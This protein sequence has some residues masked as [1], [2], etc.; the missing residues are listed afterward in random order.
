MIKED[1]TGKIFN[2]LTVL[3]FSHY[4]IKYY[5]KSL[6]PTYVYYWLCKCKCGK[7]IIAEHYHLKYGHTKSCGCYQKL[8]AKQANYIHGAEKTRVYHIWQGIKRRCLN[9]KDANYKRYGARGIK[10]C[11][12]WINDP[13]AFIEW[14]YNNGYNDTLT[15]DRI[16]VDGNYE[17]SNCRW[18]SLKE[19]AINRRNTIL[20][21]YKNKKKSLIEWC[22]I[23]NL[24][25]SK[26][27]LRIYR[28]KWSVEKAFNT[29]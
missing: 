29:P 15:I 3:K 24:K 12:E 17:P 5:K 9:T 21:N 1:F 6:K 26:I 27:Y 13:K 10:I 11:K 18:I 16:N 4:D 28:Y 7:E 8:R 20:I 23:L 14:A 19:Q 22:S 25:Y 2:F